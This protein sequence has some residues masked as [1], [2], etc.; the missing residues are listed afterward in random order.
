MLH[1]VLVY[2]LIIIIEILANLKAWRN[3][4]ILNIFVL[5][6]KN[7]EQNEKN[8]LDDAD[9]EREECIK[10]CKGTDEKK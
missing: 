7:S 9:K 8:C 6:K 10:D 2:A 1:R 5:K 3:T 4:M